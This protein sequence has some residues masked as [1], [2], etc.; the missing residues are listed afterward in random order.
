MALNITF[1]NEVGTNLNRYRAVDTSTNTTYIF[2]LARAGNITQAGTKLTAEIMNS[3]VAE[4]NR[5]NAEIT[6]LKSE[7]ASKSKVVVTAN[8]DGTVDLTIS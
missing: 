7:I 5:L 4:I 8:S 2:D 1:V 3:I 6:S